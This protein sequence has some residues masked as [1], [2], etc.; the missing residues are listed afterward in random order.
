MTN[1]WVLRVWSDEYQAKVEGL[2]TKVATAL[3]SRPE[4]A[5]RSGG[6]CVSTTRRRRIYLRLI[7]SFHSPIMVGMRALPFPKS[8]VVCCKKCGHD[9][10]AGTDGFPATSISV[11]CSLCGER[12]RYLPS[13]VIHGRPH[14]VVRKK[15]AISAPG[16]VA[17][18]CLPG[19]IAAR[20]PESASLPHW[21]RAKS[22]RRSA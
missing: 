6:I 22:G 15:R 1:L 9:V 21:Y 14:S 12:R 18:F 16:K 11:V 17:P 3:S 13:E 4:R 5:A 8:C 7:F 20:R 19:R 10:E 2:Y